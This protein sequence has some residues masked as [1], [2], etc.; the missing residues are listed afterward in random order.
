MVKKTTRT[1]T[2]HVTVSPTHFM[3]KR[4]LI[5]YAVLVFV[6]FAT[7]SMSIYLLE[8]MATA[9]YEQ[10]RLDR[11]SA[12][13]ADLQLGNSYHVAYSNLFGDKRKHSDN[14]KLTHSSRVEYGHNDTVAN[15]LVAVI[16]QVEAAGFTK[17]GIDYEGSVAEQFIYKNAE[18]EYLRLNVKTKAAQ[19]MTVYG[20]PTQEEWQNADKNAAPS[21]VT[22]LVNI[23]GSGE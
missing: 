3:I 2:R 9:R 4:S 12:T 7:I 11:I 16:K 10:T 15:T 19:D 14:P 20:V 18:G 17:V 23:D 6:T 5:S 13:Y 22:I 1:K 8:R 21:Y